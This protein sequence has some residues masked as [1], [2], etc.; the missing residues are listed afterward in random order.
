VK[1]DIT[2]ISLGLILTKL[3]VRLSN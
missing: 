1:A 3:F 2:K